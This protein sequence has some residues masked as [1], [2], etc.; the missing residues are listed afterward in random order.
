[1][2]PAILSAGSLMMLIT[3]AAAQLITLVRPALPTFFDSMI[4]VT[5]DDPSLP[6]I[7]NNM[8]I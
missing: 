5:L 4:Q 7:A 1:M 6:W 3:S 2:H 8:G